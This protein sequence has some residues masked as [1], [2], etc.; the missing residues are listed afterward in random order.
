M[1]CTNPEMW[2]KCEV[3]QLSAAAEGNPNLVAPVSFAIK[4]GQQSERPQIVQHR[5]LEAFGA[6]DLCSTQIVV[7]AGPTKGAHG[8]LL[9]A[10]L[11]DPRLGCLSSLGYNGLGCCSGAALPSC[12]VHQPI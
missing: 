9:L 2:S 5:K 3:S 11:N 8:A 4:L 7:L 12:I 1:G 10:A 6:D